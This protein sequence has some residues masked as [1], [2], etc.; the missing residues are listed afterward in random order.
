VDLIESEI[1]IFYKNKKIH[2]ATKIFQ[3][4]RITVNDEIE[5]LKKTIYEG[6]EILKSRGIFSIV[7]FHSLEDKVVKKIFRE[8]E[9]T[10]I[11]KRVNKKV[12]KPSRKEVEENRRSRSAKLRVFRKK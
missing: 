12:I 5:N 3:A 6:V 7:T 2:P 4:L 8:L 10:D 9:D 1:G 11:G